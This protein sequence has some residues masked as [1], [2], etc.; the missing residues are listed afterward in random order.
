MEDRL[1]FQ[2]RNCMEFNIFL[3]VF[4]FF[5]RKGLDVKKETSNRGNAERQKATNDGGFIHRLLSLSIC[6]QTAVL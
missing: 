1:A 5:T 2:Q 4:D 6:P 3:R